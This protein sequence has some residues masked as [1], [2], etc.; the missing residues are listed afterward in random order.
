[1]SK[2][3]RKKKRTKK[4]NKIKYN[5]NKF[6]ILHAQGRLTVAGMPVFI[7]DYY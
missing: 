1:M 3:A 5:H 6:C 4:Y 2:Q 7:Y